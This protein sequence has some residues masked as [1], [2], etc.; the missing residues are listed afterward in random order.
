MLPKSTIVTLALAAVVMVGAM[1]AYRRGHLENKALMFA[2]GLLLLLF[3][4]YLLMG[5][6]GES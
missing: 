4:G 5:G 2:V 6:F 3:L 1:I